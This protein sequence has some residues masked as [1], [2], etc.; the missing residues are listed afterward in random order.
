MYMLEKNLL[1]HMCFNPLNLNY[2]H[3]YKFALVS[4]IKKFYISIIWA[5]CFV[6]QFCHLAKN[7]VKFFKSFS[8]IF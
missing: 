7:L 8:I 3:T 5:K 6:I 1:K 4:P 2:L